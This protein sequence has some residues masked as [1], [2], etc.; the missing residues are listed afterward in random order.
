MNRSQ[1]SGDQQTMQFEDGLPYAMYTVKILA[2]NIKRG[3]AYSGSPT[4]K[5]YRSIAISK[6]FYYY[7][8]G[9]N[10]GRGGAQGGIC[11][12][13]PQASMP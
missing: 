9:F 4:M 13:P 1:I 2:Y 7:H 11:P 6:S 3:R 8:T 10:L 12:P 5:T